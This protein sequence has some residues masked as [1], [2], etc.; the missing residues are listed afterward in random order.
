[1]VRKKQEGDKMERRL[2]II[3]HEFPELYKEIDAKIITMS[4]LQI[5]K[6]FYKHLEGARKIYTVMLLQVF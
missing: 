3:F 5:H 1:V 2:F 6:N 4:G